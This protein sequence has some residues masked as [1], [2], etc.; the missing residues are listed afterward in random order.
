[1]SYDGSDTKFSIGI[2]LQRGLLCFE[3][4]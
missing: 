2:T 4:V 3:S 1:L